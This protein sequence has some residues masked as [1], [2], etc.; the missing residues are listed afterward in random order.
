MK[1]IAMENINIIVFDDDDNDDENLDAVLR[2]MED[3]AL[4]SCIV[5]SSITKLLGS[6]RL[7]ERSIF[8]ISTRTET[9]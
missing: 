3:A 9:S 2:R 4:S 7:F 5:V 8:I 1:S 6:F